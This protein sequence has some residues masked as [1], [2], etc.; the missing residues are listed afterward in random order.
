MNKDIRERIPFISFVI[1]MV[2]VFYHCWSPEYTYSLTGVNFTF[3]G[4]ITTIIAGLGG[5][6]MS[7]FFGITGFLLFRGL[8]FQNVGGKIKKRVFSLLVPYVLWCLLFVLKSLLLRQQRWTLYDVFAQLFFFR[9]WPPLASFWYV[10]TVFLLALLSPLLLLAY[11]NKTVGAAFIM[12]VTFLAAGHTNFQLYLG[13][14]HSYYFGNILM[15]LPAYLVGCFYGG[16]YQEDSREANLASLRYLVLFLL[17]GYLMHYWV[18][19]I[20]MIMNVAVMPVLMLYLLPV[21]EKLKNRNIYGLLFFIYATHE[22]FIG[23]ILE[24]IYRVLLKVS[25]LTPVSG[26][27]GRSLCA[28]LVCLVNVAVC[29]LMRRF[30]PRTLKL[31]SGGRIK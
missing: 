14:G 22:A 9:T 6:G 20:F 21:P 13:N 30:T 10:Y 19:D 31:L 4:F 25:W 17:F 3:N 26:L 18:D 11:K 1:M 5:P 23:V 29:R 12:A 15:Y 8:S 16:I 24:P 27:L 28:V 7:W 2:E